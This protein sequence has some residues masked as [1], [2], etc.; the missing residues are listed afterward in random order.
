MGARSQQKGRGGEAELTGILNDAGIPAKIG[1]S[2]SYGA[3]PDIV[4]VQHVHVECK[5]CETVRL[6]EWMQQATAD[7]ARFGN[8]MPCIFHRKNRE[9]WL[10][11]MRLSDWF[12]LY[13]IYSELQ[14][15]GGCDEST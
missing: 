6:S 7:A 10:T 5:R 11:T 3:E 4:N 13:K 12:R 9:E 14:R 15:K 2:M 1:M 8:G